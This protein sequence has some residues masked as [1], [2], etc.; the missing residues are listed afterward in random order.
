MRLGP[1]WGALEAFLTGRKSPLWSD[2]VQPQLS[3]SRLPWWPE[4]ER[5][6]ERA[7]TSCAAA[8]VSRVVCPPPPPC[9]HLA[10]VLPRPRCVGAS[11]PPLTTVLIVLTGFACGWISW[12]SAL[13]QCSLLSAA[14]EVCPWCRCRVGPS[15]SGIQFPLCGRT[16]HSLSTLCNVDRYLGS[17]KADTTQADGHIPVCILRGRED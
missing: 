14:G 4:G 11:G 8:G 6:R 1:L 17:F 12:E 9:F 7:G 16:A 3:S 5:V 13:C 10:C 15:L 2:E